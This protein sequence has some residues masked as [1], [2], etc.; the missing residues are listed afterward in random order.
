[1]TSSDQTTVVHLL[2]H[3]EVHNPDGILYGR[4]PDYHLS[5]IGRQM[6]E[7]VATTV[8]DR[9]I[10]H[11]V[12]SP[13][14]RAQET[15][16]PSAEALGLEIVTDERV[17]EAAN[18]FEGQAFGVGDGALRKPVGVEAPLQP[19][20]AVVGRALQGHRGPDARRDA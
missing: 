7:R 1:M 8:K 9:D 5:D 18:Q 6:A 12:A 10:T 14:E 3:G 20:Q 16:Q 15:A 2:R 13:L 17:I 19:V 4:L 11:L